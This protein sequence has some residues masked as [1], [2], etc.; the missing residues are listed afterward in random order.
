MSQPVLSTSAAGTLEEFIYNAL[1]AAISVEQQ[2]VILAT[3]LQ[4]LEVKYNRENP[5]ETPKDRIT[6]SADYENSQINM[7]VDLLLVP[8][9]ILKKLTESVLPH[10]PDHK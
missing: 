8:D 7:T 2:F 4:F 1:M 10:I 9:A 5:T 6:V 3:H